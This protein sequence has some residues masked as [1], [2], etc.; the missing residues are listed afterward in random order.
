MET[1]TLRKSAVRLAGDG[2]VVFSGSENGGV[3][4]I[5]VVPGGSAAAAATS[6]DT[7]KVLQDVNAQGTA[8]IFT[9]RAQGRRGAGGG[10]APAQFGVL[11]LPAGTPTL[12][13][14][15]APAFSPDGRSLAF[16]TRTEPNSQLLIAPVAT[17]DRGT[18]CAPA[19][20]ASTPPRS[21]RMPAASPT[22]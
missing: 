8:V 2:V 9:H 21:P 13:T 11:A 17:P 12:V 6:G 4:Q 3:E 22:R 1:G 18:P 19:L 5:Y 14:G 7:A 15:T 10:G 20:N 16:V